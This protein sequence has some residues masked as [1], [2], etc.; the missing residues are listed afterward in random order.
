MS[1]VGD[2]LSIIYERI[3]IELALNELDP[4]DKGSYYLII[5]PECKD[6]NDRAFI[7]KNSHTIKCNRLNQC[8]YSSSLWDYIQQKGGYDKSETL[9]ELA[10]LANVTLPEM[11]E[12]YI[13]GLQI[14][15]T[16]EA[17][18]DCMMEF[19][20][21]Q[22]WS[23][24][25]KDGLMY[26]GNR[27]YTHQDIKLMGLG[28]NPGYEESIKHLTSKGFSVEITDNRHILV[29]GDANPLKWFSFRNDYKLVIPYR[30]MNGKLKALFGRLIRSLKEGEKESDKYK[31]F[32]ESEG[33]KNNPFLCDKTKGAKFALIVEGLLDALTIFAKG[34]KGVMAISGADLLEPQIEVLKSLGFKTVVLCLDNDK[35]GRTGTEKAIKKLVK[36]K[37]GFRVFV[38]TLPEG[39]K[40]PDE[41]IKANSFDDFNTLVQNAEDSVKWQARF[42]LSQSN[43][44][45]DMGFKEAL[46][47]AIEFE[48]SIINPVDSALFK[49]IVCAT[50]AISEESLNKLTLHFHEKRARENLISS[51]NDLFKEG[52]KLVDQK[53][54]VRLKQF[55]KSFIDIRLEYEKNRVEPPTP[56]SIYLREKYNVEKERDPFDLL[57]YR[58]NKFLD[59]AKY[60]DGI[61]P[62]LYI[63]AA[64][65]NIGK[66]AFLINLFLDILVANPHTKGL[67]FS[68]DDSKKVITNRL[69]AYE[70]L[71]PINQIQRKQQNSIDQE[72]VR[73]AYSSLINLYDQD[74]FNIFD[75]S[76]V[77]HIDKLELII[78]ESAQS[79]LFVFIDG[80]YNLEVSEEI[81]S[82]FQLR[83]LNIDRANK[84]KALVDSYDI[85]IVVS[86]ELRKKAKHE[87]IN[88]KPT[89]DDIMETGKLAYNANLVWLLYPENMENFKEEEEPHI[90]LDYAKNKLSWYK[91]RSMLRFIKAK[92][93]LREVREDTDPF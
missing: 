49:K 61:Q 40:D 89:I 24:K 64:E 2:I 42:L 85:P 18:L 65:T 25:G 66:T 56:Y 32:S 34:F 23:I 44:K 43:I 77:G 8:G 63:V 10:R 9:K 5:C 3:D 53:D 39:F 50:L 76:D 79:N 4:K 60:T 14:K 48:E 59:I 13:K 62:G 29:N 74:R 6:K 51:Y 26:L 46:Y 15:K 35:A 45:T 27:G 75:I 11:S 86:G 81:G 19:F 7:Y 16:R 90:I 70:S 73:E 91:G 72:K 33:I 83:E 84:I 82:Q 67:Y 37:H 52:K 47:S 36:Y 12:D 30:D 22:L 20:S 87:G 68:L 31:P 69:I 80:L 58:L 41:F 28:F 92:G 55:E 1:D 17:V 21:K 88:K 93:M 38:A 78:R 57:G 54:L 71:L